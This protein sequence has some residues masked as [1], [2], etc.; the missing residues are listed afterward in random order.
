MKKLIAVLVVSIALFSCT[1]GENA[2]KPSSTEGIIRYTNNSTNPYNIYLDG[3][4]VGSID[5]KKYFEKKVSIGTHTVKAIQ[6]SGYVLYP[7]ERTA[8]IT[9]TSKEEKEF[10]FP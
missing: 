3:G 5:G 1:K 8:T 2:G 7:T 6:A 4:S 10:V 9:L